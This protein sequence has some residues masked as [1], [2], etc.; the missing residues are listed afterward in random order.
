MP[1]LSKVCALISEL[2]TANHEQR[3][4]RRSCP[5][6]FQASRSVSSDHR[7]PIAYVEWYTPFDT[8]DTETGMFV[9]KPSTRSHHVHGEIVEVNRIVRSLHLLPRYRRKVNLGWHRMLL[10]VVGLSSLALTVI[11]ICFTRHEVCRRVMYWYLDTF[12]SSV[13]LIPFFKLTPVVMDIYTN[14]IVQCN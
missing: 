11:F 4:S 5:R 9:V 2:C 8:L 1:L 13:C 14:T 7:P 12:K 6:S 3:T 10:I